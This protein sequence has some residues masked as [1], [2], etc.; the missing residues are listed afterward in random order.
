MLQV[1]ANGLRKRA[2]LNEILA[3]L[4]YKIVAMK[5][6]SRKRM[7]VRDSG[8]SL[9]LRY[10]RSFGQ[11]FSRLENLVADLAIRQD[12]LVPVVIR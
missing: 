9:S 4:R 3:G 12:W 5:G 6:A 8:S 1:F 7:M 10:G 11:C 2:I